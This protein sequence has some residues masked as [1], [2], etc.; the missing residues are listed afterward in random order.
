MNV[1]LGVVE[2]HVNT[3]LHHVSVKFVAPWPKTVHV[4]IVLVTELPYYPPLSTPASSVLFVSLDTNIPHAA[5]FVS[6]GVFTHKPV[7]TV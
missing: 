3:A 5:L 7:A 4:G 6:F 2:M 1:Q